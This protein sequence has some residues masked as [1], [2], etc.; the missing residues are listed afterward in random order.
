MKS[1]SKTY[2]RTGFC[3]RFLLCLLTV[4]MVLSMCSGFVSA[5]GSQETPSEKLI[6]EEV[7]KIITDYLSSS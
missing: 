3:T 7:Q 6:H 4:G 1:I 2:H 5:A